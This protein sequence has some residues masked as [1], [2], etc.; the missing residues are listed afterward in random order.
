MYSKYSHP[1][2]AVL[3]HH[4]LETH[5]IQRI[6]YF[7]VSF[8]DVKS[9]TASKIDDALA[10]CLLVLVRKMSQAIRLVGAAR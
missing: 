10:P 8:F 3:L 6:F 5:V 9:K 1:A 2:P 7:H 4:H